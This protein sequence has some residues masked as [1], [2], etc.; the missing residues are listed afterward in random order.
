MPER[1]RAVAVTQAALAQV[2]AAIAALQSIGAWQAA[3]AILHDARGPFCILRSGFVRPHP[4]PFS[5][6]V[7]QENQLV[8][9]C[10]TS[11]R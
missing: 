1:V 5:G 3:L 7:R 10:R 6:E 9:P 2:P 4:Q 8:A 11:R